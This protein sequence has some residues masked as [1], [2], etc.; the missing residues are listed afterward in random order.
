MP[1]LL[2]I[3]GSGE[4]APTMVKTHRRLVEAV[5]GGPSVLLDTP[6]G[7]QE[8]AGDISD[9][10]REYFANS[11]GH[12]I[13][14]ATWR[15]EET[16]DVARERALARIAEANYVFAGPGSPTYALDV[17]RG[18]PLPG[19]L[20]DKL[21]TGGAVTFASAAALTLGVAA[22]PVYEIYKV[23]ARPFWA[24]GLDLLGAI[25]LHVALIPHY[26]N[27]E[28]GNHDTRFCYLGER[29]LSMLEPELPDGAWV[30]GVD[31][32]TALV[33]DLDAETASVEG[34]GTM[35]IRRDGS[36]TVFESGA[37][38]TLDELRAGGPRS[39]RARA[40]SDTGGAGADRGETDD[41][42]GAGRDDDAIGDD[43]RSYGLG[44]DTDRLG[45]AFDAAIEDRDTDAAV[46]AMLELDRSIDA[47]SADTL[48]SDDVDRA[49]AALRRMIVRL[50]ELAQVGV[51]DPRA[52]VAPFV[53]AALAARVAARSG[54]QYELA[55]QVRDELT[56]AGVEIR[57]TGD[58][59]E[60]LL[61]GQ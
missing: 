3:M 57:D 19:L 46:S 58:G 4:T 37:S 24:D 36:S 48:Q 40:E 52:V 42:D 9:R 60:W 5:G 30:L 7:F 29:R 59:T 16:G 53:E 6:Y 14:V 12:E 33:I 18:S 56:E 45:A 11:V 27:N 43:G 13:D 20:G 2:T 23:G 51:R 22:V 35:T 32:H 21:R 15:T 34:N 31:E 61:V 8:N 47:W 50:G 44:A 41:V 38:M 1:R 10:A 49:R 55:D 25:G 26:D 28:G 39:E 17:W 54:G